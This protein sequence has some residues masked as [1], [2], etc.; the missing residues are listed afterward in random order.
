ALQ[1]TLATP[2]SN[3]A[4][5]GNY[6][7]NFLAATALGS[8]NFAAQITSDGASTL[9]GTAD[10]GSFNATAAPPVGA[11]SSGAALAGSFT[12]SPDGRFPLTLTIAPAAGQP[13]PEF[14]I[15]HPAC[16]IVDANTCLLLGLDVTAP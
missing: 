1:Q 13:T 10:V 11:P 14:T 3:S 9:S 7:S 15:L 4:F 5:T 12:S 8:Q 2:V 16:Y 6:A